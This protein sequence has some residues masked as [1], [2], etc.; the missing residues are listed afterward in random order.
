MQQD[1]VLVISLILNLLFV[2]IFILNKVITDAAISVINDVVD[3]KYMTVNR[4]LDVYCSE[5]FREIVR[6]QYETQGNMTKDEI[7]ANLAHTDF[8]CMQNDSERYFMEGYMNYLRS[9]GI[10]FDENSF[11]ID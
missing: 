5:E 1:L 4:G 8:T 11:D 2:I 9:Q 3:D 10:P 7:E 6:R